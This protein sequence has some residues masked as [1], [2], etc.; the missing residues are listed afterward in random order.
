[1]D[2]I[3]ILKT[4]KLQEED[5]VSSINIY[6]EAWIDILRKEF[7]REKDKAIKEIVIQQFVKRT[8]LFPDGQLSAYHIPSKKVIGN[9]SAL[10]VDSIYNY[11]TWNSLT[12]NG[13]FNT[14]K[15][16]G[17]HIVCPAVNSSK[18]TKTL[19]IKGVAKKLILEARNTAISLKS[20]GLESMFVF[21]RPS[22]FGKFAEKYKDNK[23]EDYF[24]TK[25]NGK[26]SEFPD[27]VDLHLGLGA[28]IIYPLENAI[29]FLTPFTSA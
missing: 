8:R 23:I 3:G 27:P 4:S 7:Y 26:P 9:I 18:E 29:I 12:G 24:K 16:K 6:Y 15:Q 5:I 11:E 20:D 14:H 1:M 21:T 2:E 19:G 28:K 25:L 10:R 17:K 22:G 13:Y